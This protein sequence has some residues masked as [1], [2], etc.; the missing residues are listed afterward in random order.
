MTNKLKLYEIFTY[1]VHCDL[2]WEG[3][4]ICFSKST[5]VAG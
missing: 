3:P 2:T 1:D 5:V 4:V